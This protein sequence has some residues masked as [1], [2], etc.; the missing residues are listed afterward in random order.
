MATAPD[1]ES[2][3]WSD[4]DMDA[5]VALDAAGRDEYGSGA[6][7]GGQRS[8]ANGGK[9]ALKL[10]GGATNTGVAVGAGAVMVAV[11][12]V[13]L[14]WLLGRQGQARKRTSRRRTSQSDTRSS[15]GCAFTVFCIQFH[16]AWQT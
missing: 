1:V 12:A 2:D 8:G 16:L 5:L 6:G 3:L 11:T 9:R 10:G 4:L 14:R 7:G 15:Q 13:G